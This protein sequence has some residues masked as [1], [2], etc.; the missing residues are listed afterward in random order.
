MDTKRIVDERGERGERGE[1][2]E[3]GDGYFIKIMCVV[4]SV[5]CSVIFLIK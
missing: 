2:G 3:G 1:G 5:Y 4:Y